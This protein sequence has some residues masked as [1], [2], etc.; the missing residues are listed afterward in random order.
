MHKYRAS[1][2]DCDARALKA[3]CC[4]KEPMRKVPRGIHEKARDDTRS[5]V[6]TADFL[7]SWDERKKGEMR[8]AHLKT[9]HGF[10]RM[11]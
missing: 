6:G 11:R 1:K 2:R 8:F 7:R 9:H 4:P 10:E 5:L 3:R